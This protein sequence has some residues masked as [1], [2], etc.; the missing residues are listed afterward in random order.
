MKSAPKYKPENGA[1][2]TK[3]P[4]RNPR[5]DYECWYFECIYATENLLRISFM[6]NDSFSLPVTYG[7]K[8]E[9]IDKQNTRVISESFNSNQ[10]EFN[11]E[12][13]NHKFG[14]NWMLDVGDHFEIHIEINGTT[15]H[16]KYDPE[17]EGFNN[18]K[19]HIVNQ[20]IL[21][22]KFIAWNSP[23]P[24][25]NV[26]GF[27]EQ[28]GKKSTIQGV[29]YHDH[30][31]SNTAQYKD[32]K[33]LYLGKIFEKEFSIFYTL[34]FDDKESVFTKVI[35]AKDDKIL[36][37]AEGSSFDK[38]KKITVKDHLTLEQTEHSIPANIKIKNERIAL[39]IIL[40]DLVQQKLKEKHRLGGCGS[41]TFK[42]EEFFKYKM[43]GDEGISFNAKSIHEVLIF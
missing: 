10:V 1:L 30:V 43:E 8:V 25:A 20:N 5:E 32:I 13:C 3:L 31:W 19:D 7:V 18:K 11:I 16:L 39:D 14:N 38:N 37:N 36:F 4:V 28:N 41:L 2:K 24:R 27:T 9:F 23:V 29:G 6:I 35:V 40:K 34:L 12:K 15:I 21:G 17:L 26:T 33:Y 42:G 22:T